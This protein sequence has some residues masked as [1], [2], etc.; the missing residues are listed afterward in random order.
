[1]MYVAPLE[2][3]LLLN[4][5][6]DCKLVATYKLSQR[7][8]NSIMNMGCRVC[9]TQ[10]S[11]KASSAWSPNALHNDEVI[12]EISIT[13]GT[14]WIRVTQTEV[15]LFLVEDLVSPSICNISPP[16]SPMSMQFNSAWVVPTRYMKMMNKPSTQ[17][18]RVSKTWTNDKTIMLE[19][20]KKCLNC[21][22][23]FMKEE[24]IILLIPCFIIRSIVAGGPPGWY[25]IVGI[26][27]VTLLRRS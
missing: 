18:D 20:V 24:M 13:G 25:I 12:I 8:C 6:T 23:C 9:F 19:I 1:M 2:L 7:C 14:R 3:T 5:G 4:T 16:K 15:D 22:V 27:G 11:D 10:N 26:G 17:V 21:R